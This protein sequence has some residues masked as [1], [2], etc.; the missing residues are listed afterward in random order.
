M[1][2]SSKNS[3]RKW[4]F[5]GPDLC[6]AAVN[7]AVS[8]AREDGLKVGLLDADVYGPSIPH[9]MNLSGRPHVNPGPPLFPP[10]L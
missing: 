7:I 6:A 2:P 3:F 1:P 4:N 5:L 10:T 9:M 8:L